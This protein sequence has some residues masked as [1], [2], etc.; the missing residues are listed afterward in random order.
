MN[1]PQS[2]TDEQV[3]AVTRD[4]FGGFLARSG[5]W[6]DD[7]ARFVASALP[8]RPARVL[9]VGAFVGK[10]GIGLSQVTQVSLLA[11]VEANPAIIPTL[12]DNVQRHVNT[13]AQVVEAAVAPLQSMRQEPS[14]RRSLAWRCV[15][16]AS[17]LA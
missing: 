1:L 8:N 13:P 10:F 15:V 6:V 4:L 14:R 3:A 12:R 5:D 7:E 9:D 2:Q 11:A 17:A 16:Q